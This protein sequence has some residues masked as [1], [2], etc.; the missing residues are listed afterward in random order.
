[1]CGVGRSE[2]L[3]RHAIARRATR[4]VGVEVCTALDGTLV[5]RKDDITAL[6]GLGI[7]IAVEDAGRALPS[8]CTG[9]D[10]V[11]HRNPEPGN[12]Y[13]AEGDEVLCH[14]QGPV[15]WDGEADA[16]RPG[17]SPC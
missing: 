12:P 5:D 15:G 11:L 13:L 8:S 3:D 2:D 1:M 9:E 14:L 7:V 4:Q 17:E 10:H 16:G 6:K